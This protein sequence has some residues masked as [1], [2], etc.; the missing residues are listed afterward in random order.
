MRLKEK[1]ESVKRN[2]GPGSTSRRCCL[3]CGSSPIQTG[4]KP[5]EG[6][7]TGQ[8][9]CHLI[10][11]CQ[12]MFSLLSRLY[13]RSGTLCSAHQRA[14]GSLGMSKEDGENWTFYVSYHQQCFPNI[15][16]ASLW[17]GWHTGPY[18]EQPYQSVT[19]RLGLHVLPQPLTTCIPRFSVCNSLVFFSNISWKYHQPYA[20]STDLHVL[21]TINHQH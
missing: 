1:K 2:I 5:W 10:S 21:I 6:S 11:C 3:H 13:L 4:I 7:E 19:L 12:P 17:R 15:Q 9:H 16:H 20:L 14:I 18:I 8:K